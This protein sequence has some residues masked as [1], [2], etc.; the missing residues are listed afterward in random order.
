MI[1]KANLG[2]SKKVASIFFSLRVS[3]FLPDNV[4]SKVQQHKYFYE[5]EAV[6]HVC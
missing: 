4:D 6:F 2:F 3:V 5:N 1:E